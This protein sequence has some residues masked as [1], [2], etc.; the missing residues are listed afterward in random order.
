MPAP[1]LAALA[2]LGFGLSLIVAIGAQNA[3]VLRQGLI[4]NRV[5][6]IVTICAV[7]DVALIF[8]G[9]AGLGALIT[10]V[11]WLLPAIELVGGVFV[12]TYGVF[13]AKRAIS[14]ESLAP[15]SQTAGLTT[16]AAITATLGLT[17]LNPHV[18]LD[19]VLLLG[20]VASTYGDNRWWF[21]IGA[22]I[23]S[24]TWF[25]SLGFGARMFKPVFAKPLAWR[26]L[27]IA[28]AVVMF[29]IAAT[30]LVGFVQHV[31]VPITR[32]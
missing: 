6:I 19:T 31:T 15:T 28:I 8:A 13:A 25:F 22:G 14:S 4:R 16:T 32:A 21:G 12:A 3:F 26:I 24:V 11:G 30:L 9:I 1:L 27:D 10:S 17:L 23:G 7:A 2:G 29:V 5:F 18:Y 20:S